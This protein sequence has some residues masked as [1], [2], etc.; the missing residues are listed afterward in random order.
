MSLRGLRLSLGREIRETIVKFF[1]T[2]AFTV[3]NPTNRKTPREVRADQVANRSI[4]P[5][6]EDF[7]DLTLTVPRRPTVIPPPTGIRSRPLPIA[8][9]P[10]RESVDHHLDLTGTLPFLPGG[11]T[12]T[13][14][15][16]RPVPSTAGRGHSWASGNNPVIPPTRAPIIDDDE[17]IALLGRA[18]RIHRNNTQ[19]KTR[20]CKLCKRSIHN[21]RASNGD[22]LWHVHIAGQSH[23]RNKDKADPTWARKCHL[24]K[25][26]FNSPP[27]SR[28]HFNG[29]VHAANSRK[30]FE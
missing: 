3:A 19:S 6:P 8:P 4:P 11:Y 16:S 28:K 5:E 22:S 15:R 30:L 24:C 2:F 7:I 20:W 25:L 9:P 21:G 29:R 23:Q 10:G 1:L 26:S 18:Y 27:E 14:L 12:L 13:G 17:N